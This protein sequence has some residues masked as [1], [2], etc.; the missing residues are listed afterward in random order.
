MIAIVV[1]MTKKGKVIGKDGKL[2]W[3]IPEEMAHFR[4]LT[5]NG[6]VIMGRKTFDSIGYPLPGRPNI[7]VS[8]S[9]PSIPGCEIARSIPQ[10]VDVAKKHHKDI[11][12]IGG[13][14]IAKEGLAVADTMML[15]YIKKE[16]SGD[17]FFPDFSGKD[18]AVEKRQDFPEF[19][20]V[21]YRKR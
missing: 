7:V 5:K 6:V 3:D 17:T 21:V 15:S 18:W 1:A 9:T 10:A 13:A 16:Y 19:E 14:Q 20:F 11:F 8:T 12:I 2:P 4:G